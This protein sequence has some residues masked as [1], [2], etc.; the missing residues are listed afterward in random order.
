MNQKNTY[1][2]LKKFG[3]SL[4]L[5]FVFISTSGLLNE[6][7]AAQKNNQKSEQKKSKK[8]K[9]SNESSQ[10]IQIIQKIEITG[11]KKIEKE[12]VLLKISSKVG[13][14]LDRAVIAQDIQA[15][16]RMNFL[17]KLKSK[18]KLLQTV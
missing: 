15:L 4:F 9:S 10:A 14:N 2:L 8:T 11:L 1:K 3:F 13:Q 7:A 5:S 18:K 12:A 16:F 6:A 17:C